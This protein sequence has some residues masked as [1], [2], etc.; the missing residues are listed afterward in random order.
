M[1]LD[2][3]AKYLQLG[4]ASL[5]LK[6]LV[7]VKKMLVPF[8]GKSIYFIYV[9][10][11]KSLFFYANST[12]YSA[13][14]SFIVNEKEAV[15]GILR[16]YANTSSAEHDLWQQ[17]LSTATDN[18]E[19]SFFRYLCSCGLDL[20]FAY[21]HSAV[22]PQK[23][24]SIDSVY[25]FLVSVLPENIKETRRKKALHDEEV[26]KAKLRQQE[27]VRK[28]R[29]DQAREAFE[30]ELKQMEEVARAKRQKEEQ[31][32]EAEKAQKKEAAENVLQKVLS[33]C[34]EDFSQ[35]NAYIKNL[36]AQNGNNLSKWKCSATRFLRNSDRII[37]K[38]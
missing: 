24:D 17:L 5:C 2:I 22:V 7:A 18:F 15:R 34:G 14:L 23:V 8:G 21:T 11:G 1:N 20:N 36:E 13:L 38:K 32:I 37:E 31:K 10:S 16:K 19:V 30:A 27:K 12:Q 6:E 35:G 9:N 4:N 25:N 28:Q 26:R 3:N 33:V 29:E